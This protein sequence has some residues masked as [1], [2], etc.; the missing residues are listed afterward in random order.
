M[1]NK[2]LVSINNNRDEY[3]T[4][5]TTQFNSKKNSLFQWLTPSIFLTVEY[6]Q[7]PTIIQT[8]VHG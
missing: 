6:R 8:A 7:S 1:F 3:I 4:R 2:K 5:G